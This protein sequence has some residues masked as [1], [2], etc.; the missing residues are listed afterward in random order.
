MGDMDTVM[1]EPAESNVLVERARS[2]DREAFDEL[3]AQAR[4][5]L[6]QKIDRM[7]GPRLREKAEPEDVL[8]EVF[9]RGLESIARFD[10]NDAEAFQRWL[11]GIARNVVRNLGRRKSWK[12]E[13]ELTHDVP[14]SGSSP[15][16][17]QRREERFE[18]LS[19]AV[20]SLSPDYR[21]V[22][23][24]ARIEG[25]KIREVAERMNRSESAV[26]NLLLRAMKELRDSFGETDSFRL[27]DRRLEGKEDDDAR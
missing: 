12:K 9:L 27:P 18:R 14:A 26:K 16:R 20:E 23:R 7:V 24:L 8:Q 3:A 10:G 19:K 21:T 11:E 22:I 1:A 25:L 13:F 15:S 5:R 2:G 6:L 4:S 17:H